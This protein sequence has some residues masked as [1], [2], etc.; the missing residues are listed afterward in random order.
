MKAA[1]SRG[2]KY[3]AVDTT[4]SLRLPARTPLIASIWSSSSAQPLLDHLR[5][6]DERPDLRQW[7]ACRPAV[8]S[9]SVS[10]ISS[11]SCRS[12][13]VT[14]GGDRPN[15]LAALTILPLAGDRLDG[16]ELLEGE[17]AHDAIVRYF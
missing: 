16:P 11:S 10:P 1:I 13:I 2:A 8:R 6:I 12:W 14:A 15:A 17:I 9:N 5:G 3:F 7:D 4:P